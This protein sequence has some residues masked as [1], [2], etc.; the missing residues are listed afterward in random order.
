MAGLKA[1]LRAGL[2][3]SDRSVGV[4]ERFPRVVGHAARTALASPSSPGASVG[5]SLKSV[6]LGAVEGVLG[7]FEEEILAAQITAFVEPFEFSKGT[8]LTLD[9]SKPADDSIRKAYRRLLAS[10]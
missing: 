2:L 5:E 3:L 8:V 10:T 6:G 1:V 9:A 7:D 4:R